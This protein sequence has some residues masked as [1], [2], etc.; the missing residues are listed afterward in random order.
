MINLSVVVLTKDS[1][2][3][4]DRCLDSLSFASEIIVVDDESNDNTQSISKKYTKNLN[5]HALENDFSRQRNYSLKLAKYEWVLF[6]DSDEVVSPGLAREI[7]SF[8]SNDRGVDGLYL[9]R[10]DIMWGKKLKHGDARVHLLRLARK[11][12]GEW[13]GSVHEEWV[14]NGEVGRLKSPLLHY[15]HPSVR[16]FLS[17]V[18]YYSSLRAKE[19]Y[20]KKYNVNLLPVIYYPLGKFLHIYF[21]KLG[22]LDGIQGLISALMM[23]FYSFLVRAKLWELYE[24]QNGRYHK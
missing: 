19:L 20:I 4:L 1:G 11:G 16:E 21:V 22:I 9:L 12:K 15:P 18:N 3:Y 13:V 5:T 10:E 8:L 7:V 6:V 14:I 2:K 17:E 24:K 23:S